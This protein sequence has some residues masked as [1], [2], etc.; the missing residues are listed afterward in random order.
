MSTTCAAC[1]QAVASSWAFCIGCGQ[2]VPRAC[3]VCWAPVSAAANWCGTCGSKVG[4]AAAPAGAAAPA[5]QPPAQPTPPWAAPVAVAGRPGGLLRAARRRPVLIAGAA[6]AMVAVLVATTV[7]GG[8]L[9][10]NS[11]SIPLVETT[12]QAPTVIDVPTDDSTLSI[13]PGQENQLDTEG[14]ALVIPAGA[15]SPNTTV[16]VKVLQAPFH[17]TA[18]AP[19]QDSQDTGYA[20]GPVVDFGPEG[21]TFNE[22]VTISVPYDHTFLPKGTPKIRS[23]RLIGTGNPGSWSPGSWTRVRTPSAS[24][25]RTS[26]ASRFLPS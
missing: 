2:P 12:M 9:P 25:S 22:P 8:R 16:T 11:P 24:I 17:M 19:A 15:A 5:P 6:V 23:A 20:V 3:S 1:G 26:K 18:G 14:A 7:F 21:T 10:W 13:V 4:A